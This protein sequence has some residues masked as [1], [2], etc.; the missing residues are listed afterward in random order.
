MTLSPSTVA[1]QDLA[2][3]DHSLGPNPRLLARERRKGIGTLALPVI[4]GNSGGGG[5]AL[6]DVFCHLAVHVN[7]GGDGD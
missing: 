7:G 2:T 4:G 6:G 1:R 5:I 3:R